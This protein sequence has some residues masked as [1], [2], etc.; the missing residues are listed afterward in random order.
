MLLSLELCSTFSISHTAP[1]FEKLKL[2]GGGL[3]AA[4]DFKL[5]E[6]ISHSF[7]KDIKEREIRWIFK[8]Q[9]NFLFIYLDLK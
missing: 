3:E 5:D 4:M 1:G 2:Q 9:C 6:Y 7:K 8:M